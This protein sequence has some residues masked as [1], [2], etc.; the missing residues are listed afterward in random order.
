MCVAFR[1]INFDR[2]V[3]VLFASYLAAVPVV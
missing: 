1:Y 2:Y 3:H